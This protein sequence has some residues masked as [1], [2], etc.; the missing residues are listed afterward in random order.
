ML[1]LNVQKYTGN[2]LEASTEMRSFSVDPAMSLPRK[3]V[4]P[5]GDQ[6]VFKITLVRYIETGKRKCSVLRDKTCIS[7]PGLTNE[8]VLAVMSLMTL[9]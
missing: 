2:D 8:D 7:I 9:L 5:R 3:D 6:R 4:Y 1:E